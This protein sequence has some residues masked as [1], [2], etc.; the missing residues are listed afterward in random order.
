[1][2]ALFLLAL[3]VAVGVS[4]GLVSAGFRSRPDRAAQGALDAAIALAIPIIGPLA[5]L[6]AIA[7]E[8][9]FRRRAAVPA[10]DFSADT[11]RLRLLDPVE[12]LRIGTT[13]EPV[14]DV[15]ARGTLE[16]VDRALRRLVRTDRPSSLLLVRDALQSDRLDVRVRVRGLIVRVEDRLIE[17]ART[18]EDPLERARASRALA[19]LSADP[20]RLRDHLVDAVAAYEKALAVDPGGSAGGEL[21]ELLLRMGD[22]ER[23]RRTLTGHLRRHPDDEGAR[24]CRAQASLRAADLSAARDD[25]SVLHRQDPE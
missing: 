14:A 16:E 25:C 18:A 15:L 13:V 3:H 5:V 6:A 2:M 4:T 24:L 21:G 1:M 22:L 17:R 11:P 9:P 7:F 10:P 23:A 8:L 12:E 19:C 20:V